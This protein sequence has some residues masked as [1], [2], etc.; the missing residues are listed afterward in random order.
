[1][2]IVKVIFKARTKRGKALREK[3][4]QGLL[5][6]LFW[7]KG[8]TTRAQEGFLWVKGLGTM[9]GHNELLLPKIFTLRSILAEGYVHTNRR[10]PV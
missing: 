4:L 8:D 3:R 9:P 6:P 1:M 5:L 10:V 2:A 7:D